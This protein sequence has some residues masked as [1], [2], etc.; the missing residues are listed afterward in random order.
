MELINEFVEGSGEPEYPLIFTR[1][2]YP[3]IYV[4]QSLFLS[5]LDKKYDE[6]APILSSDNIMNTLTCE[7]W[8]DRIKRGL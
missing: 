4:K 5:L 6:L 2:L 1:Y 8:A 3:K 7:Y